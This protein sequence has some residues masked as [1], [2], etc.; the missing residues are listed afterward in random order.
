MS[1]DDLAVYRDLGVKPVINAMG[2]M[3]VYGGSRPS[4][5][6]QAAMNHASRYFADMEDLLKKSGVIIADLLGGEAAMVTPGCAAA[7]AL[8]SATCMAGDDPDKIQ[9]LPDTAGM[10]NEIIIQKSQRYHY[11]RCITVFGAKMVEAGDEHT[12]AEQIEATINDKTAAMH[13]V[14]PGGGA[15]VVSLEEVISI[16]HSHDIPVIVD[17][18]SQ[19]YPLDQM[20]RYPAAGA[21]MI[22]YGAKYFGACNSTGVL[23]GRKD[24]IDAAFVHSFI[25]YE[26]QLS[27]SVG[28]PL[29]L[30]R[31]E[32]VAVVAALRE[33]FSMDHAARIAEHGWKARAIQDALD[34][35]A[36]IT[37][38]PVTDEQALGNGLVVNLDE[39][40]LG[41]TA[42]EIAATLLD[43]DP[44]IVLH[45]GNGSLHVAVSNLI[46]DD[47]QVV[48]DRLRAILTA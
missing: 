38:Q 27:R 36:H 3:T 25:G 13:Y 19:V 34:G 31:Q 9:Q 24:L 20:R 11:D 43:G 37:C 39:G 42:S 41:K 8:S 22:G 30:D 47:L 6:V 12:T 44:S 1:N 16:A 2:F 15:G 48:A 7:L 10:K 29:K 40:A 32:I 4:P 17:A 28:R 5:E 26:T 35:V 23:C 21:D 46:E 18:A 33:W 45:G 14:A